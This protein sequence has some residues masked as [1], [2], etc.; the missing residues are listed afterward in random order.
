[1]Y[2]A[3]IISDSQNVFAYLSIKI[4]LLEVLSLSGTARQSCVA[5]SA[6]SFTRRGENIWH[7]SLTVFNKQNRCCTKF[8]RYG[9]QTR[10]RG[11]PALTYHQWCRTPSRGHGSAP[12]CTGSLP[13]CTCPVSGNKTPNCSS[14]WRRWDHQVPVLTR[15]SLGPAGNTS[16]LPRI[17]P[18]SQKANTSRRRGDV[19]LVTNFG[20]Q[21]SWFQVS[22]VLQMRSTPFGML[23]NDDW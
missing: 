18:V 21:I 15:I 6:T 23:H 22:E 4:S 2:T 17:F 11:W 13:P 9:R 3:H 16:P 12:V 7:W 20:K 5:S 1:M 14:S 10:H 8:K 19:Y